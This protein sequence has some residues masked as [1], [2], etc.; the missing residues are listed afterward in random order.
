MALADMNPAG[1]ALGA[2]FTC[3]VVGF[4]V[5]KARAKGEAE[6]W[7]VRHDRA[8]LALEDRGRATCGRAPSRK[9]H[10]PREER[11]QRA[12]RAQSR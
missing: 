7:R 1:A 2:L 11:V 8:V 10:P 6:S 3:G 5:G 9:S 4:F 12:A